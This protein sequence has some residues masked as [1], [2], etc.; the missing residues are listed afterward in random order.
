MKLSDLKPGDRLRCDGGFTCIP[1]GAVR[2]VRDDAGDLFIACRKGVHRLA[3]LIHEDDELI[4]V[5]WV[6]RQDG[7]CRARE[8]G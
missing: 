7:R 5:G 4:G 6:W 8:N 2:V 3:G 1:A